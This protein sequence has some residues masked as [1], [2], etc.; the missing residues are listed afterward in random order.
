[1]PILAGLPD[2]RARDRCRLGG[3]LS[4]RPHSPQSLQD[5]GLHTFP[6]VQI[7]PP[8][9]VAAAGLTTQMAVW[10]CADVF[11]HSRLPQLG[12]R[13]VEVGDVRVAITAASAFVVLDII[14]AAHPATAVS[15]V[16]TQICIPAC[17]SLACAPSLGSWNGIFPRHGNLGCFFWLLRDDSDV[18]A[19]SRLQA[20]EILR[21]AA[22][23]TAANMTVVFRALP[24]GSP[25]PE[26][27]RWD[28]KGSDVRIVIVTGRAA[29][30]LD[31]ITAAK[32]A[33]TSPCAACIRVPWAA[34]VSQDQRPS[35]G[36]W[37]GL[38]PEDGPRG[39]RRGPRLGAAWEVRF[40][41]TLRL[42]SGACSSRAL[43]TNA[44]DDERCQV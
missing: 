42:Q 14:G 36:A 25:F 43:P 41:E 26:M 3:L 32:P 28:V 27:R 5:C 16:I 7:P 13:D 22:A 6:L 19:L 34:P 37:K 31:I 20:P 33:A 11:L 2:L 38:G 23:G 21:I 44:A 12:C 18:L 39:S 17:A 1:M 30:L 35:L 15:S 24:L 4:Q 10:R 9:R 8:L 29:V 40:L